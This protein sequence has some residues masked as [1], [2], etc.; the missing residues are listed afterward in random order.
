MFNC[1]DKTGAILRASRSL[2]TLPTQAAFSL[3]AQAA[4]GTAVKS[5]TNDKAKPA[6]NANVSKNKPGSFIDDILPKTVLNFYYN[7]WLE[8]QK[9]ARLPFKYDG[10]TMPNMFPF[11]VPL[12]E[13]AKSKEKERIRTA[14]QDGTYQIDKAYEGELTKK[15]QA[16]YCAQVDASLLNTYEDCAAPSDKKLQ[17]AADGGWNYPNLWDGDFAG[18]ALISYKDFK[19]RLADQLGS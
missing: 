8:G 5:N 13:D 2:F 12:S 15:L 17:V 1:K 11:S 7:K 14:L 6:A 3:P 18:H 9:Q 10:K 4:F 16:A 19:Q